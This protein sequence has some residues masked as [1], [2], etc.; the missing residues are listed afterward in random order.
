[1]SDG[2]DD[3][4]EATLA[5]LRAAYAAGMPAM[6]RSALDLFDEAVARP[7]AAAEARRLVHRLRGTAGSYGFA[8][9]GEAAAR[10]EDALDAGEP[11]PQHLIDHL[12]AMALQ[13]EGFSKG[14][15]K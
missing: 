10:I 3:D 5:A 9:V 8:A 2:D 7:E 1:M 13:G 11:V 12:A 15:S 6:V 4:V 14:S